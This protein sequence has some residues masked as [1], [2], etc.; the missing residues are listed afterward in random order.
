MAA[1]PDIDERV[2]QLVSKGR[3]H[4]PGY[5]VCNSWST[6]NYLCMISTTLI[7]STGE[8]WR[9]LGTVAR[10]VYS[11]FLHFVLQPRYTTLHSY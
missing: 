4:V 6:R 7:F 10:I 2:S 5:K 11:T 3:W 9:P 1:R 8:I